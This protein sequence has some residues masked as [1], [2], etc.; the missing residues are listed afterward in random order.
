MFNYL[1]AE[2]Y[3]QFQSKGMFIYFGILAAIFILY[4]ILRK[5]LSGSI[6]IFDFDYFKQM[7]IFLIGTFVFGTSYTDDINNKTLPSIIGNGL[8]RNKIWISKFIEIV[9]NSFL[10]CF[11]SVVYM[12]IIFIIFGAE[13]NNDIARYALQVVVVQ[14]LAIILYAVFGSIGA[15]FAQKVQPA[16]IFFLFFSCFGQL[17]SLLLGINTVVKAVGHIDNYINPYTVVTNLDGAISGDFS[18]TTGVITYLVMTAVLAI[19]SMWILKK[20]ELEF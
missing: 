19:V 14:S 12:V 15:F 6:S 7:F 18:M 9:I 8:S 1:K 5:T 16:I 2:F 13:F 3:K 4:A 11:L 17:I 10:F 20:K